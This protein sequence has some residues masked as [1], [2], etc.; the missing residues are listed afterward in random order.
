MLAESFGKRGLFKKLDET[1]GFV[2]TFKNRTRQTGEAV[3]LSSLRRWNTPGLA[4]AA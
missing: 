3:V 4:R 1:S 2:K